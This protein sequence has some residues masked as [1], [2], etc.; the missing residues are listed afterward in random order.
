VRGSRH[1]STKQTQQLALSRQYRRA[2]TSAEP[3]AVIPKLPTARNSKQTEANEARLARVVARTWRRERDP[4]HLPDKIWLQIFSYL[5]Y[6]TL[7]KLHLVSKTFCNI[8]ASRE[9]DQPLFRLNKDTVPSAARTLSDVARYHPFVADFWQYTGHI[10]TI[11]FQVGGRDRIGEVEVQS[12]HA[13]CHVGCP[14]TLHGECPRKWGSDYNAKCYAK[15]RSQCYAKAKCQAKCDR[16]CDRPEPKKW[17]LQTTSIVTDSAFWPPALRKN[18]SKTGHLPGDDGDFIT[19][20]D[21][22]TYLRLT[23]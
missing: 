7:K 5:E 20:L 14:G 1:E 3:E 18:F 16:K 13:M 2:G 9:F 15:C 6:N 4:A 21:Y 10:G 19:V 12:H 17:E 8:L 22:M 23:G 11:W